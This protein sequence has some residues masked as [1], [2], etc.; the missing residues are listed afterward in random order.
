[1]AGFDND[2]LFSVNADYSNALS[3]TGA[4]TTGQLLTNGQLWIGS[5]ATN[6]GGTHVNV[7]TITSPGGT[8]TIGYSSPNITLDL[9]GG[10]AAVEHL[11]ADSGGQLNPVANNFNIFGRS[12]SKTSG[13]GA[14]ITV[15]SPPYA[16]V[17]GSGSVTLNSGSFAT[18]AITLT[19]PVTAGLADGDLVEFVARNGVLVIQLAATQVAHLGS[20]STS[21]AGTITG[22]ATGDAL[23]LRYQASTNTWWATCIVGI[24]M[25]A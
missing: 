1:M 4:S 16:D 17:A 3:G 24:W 11:T 5:T 2:I 18:N 7:G 21:I 22:S 8:V 14:T 6:A 9:A 20:A 15:N 25:L 13:T 23:V 19:T 12:G 10:G